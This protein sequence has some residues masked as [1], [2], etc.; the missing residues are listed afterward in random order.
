[1]LE[2]VGEVPPLGYDRMQQAWTKVAHLAKV[3]GRRDC[4]TF[5]LASMYH[6]VSIFLRVLEY[7]I[8]L[9][10]IPFVFSYCTMVSGEVKLRGNP[11]QFNNSLSFLGTLWW[12]L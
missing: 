4:K 11:L 5:S 9:F 1:M 7:A 10:L 2:L 12:S 6:L 3:T 8:C